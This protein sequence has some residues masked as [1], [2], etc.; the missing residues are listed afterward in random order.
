MNQ[1]LHELRLKFIIREKETNI[2]VAAFQSATS[3][4]NCL[5]NN[6]NRVDYE[7]KETY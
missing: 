1:T 2:I 6:W 3:A 5:N 7:I 4:N